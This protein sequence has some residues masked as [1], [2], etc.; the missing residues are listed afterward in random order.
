MELERILKGID[1]KCKDPITGCDISEIVSN[2]K[3][4]RQGSLFVA[5]KGPNV[6][7]HDFIEDAMRNGAKVVLCERDFSALDGTIKVLT[8]DSKLAL[9]K[10]ASSFYGNPTL[11]LKLIGITGTNGKTTTAFLIRAILEEAGM[12]CG[13]I[14]T[15]DYKL[16]TRTLISKNTTPGILELEG[17]FAEMV[18]NNL[19][20]VAMEVSSHSLEQDRVSG[21]RFD[22]G[23]FTNLT[24]DHL[25]YHKDMEGYFQAKLKLFSAL[26][27][28][29]C[30]VTNLDDPY[31]KRVIAASSSKL[32]T[33]SLNDKSADIFVHSIKMD[34]HGT[35]FSIS[36]PHGELDIKTPLVGKHNIYN[37][38]ASFGSVSP[39]NIRPELIKKAVEKFKGAPGRLEA[40]PT[41]KPFRVFVDYAHTDDALKNV[42][43]TLKGI[44]TSRI[45][46]VFGCGGDRD[47]LKRPKMGRVATELSD[48]CIITSDNPRS[49]EP[50][51][52]IDEIK[53]G[54][55]SNNY[56]IHVDRYEAIR[57]A[58]E[59]AKKDDIV[60]LAGKGHEVYQI[61]KDRTIPFDDREVARELLNG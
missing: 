17:L 29:A 25:D 46:T 1:Y 54:I 21:L 16:G 49:E 35:S 50:L 11:K 13:M 20:H 58:L 30:C 14:G 9:F 22:V 37:I 24:Q 38:L 12:G 55:A 4:A 18:S 61:Y 57:R 41:N 48:Y 7:G 23:C 6:D 60:L 44:A 47:R 2:S 45:I 5:V 28:N 59:I 39:F 26:N 53:K 33:Y 15:V 40:V 52:I 27:D 10:A 56:E 8:H 32:I 36:S 51:S 3:D 43:I 42:L 19:T 34:M 31:G